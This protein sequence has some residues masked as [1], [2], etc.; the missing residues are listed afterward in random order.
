MS[1]ASPKLIYVAHDCK[2]RSAAVVKR[3]G[4]WA[5]PYVGRHGWVSMDVATVD[6]WDEVKAMILESY[7]LIA[8]KRSLAK[9][10]D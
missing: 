6:E 7:R 5:A 2:S 4:F 8:P 10:V 3:S 1:A 9:L